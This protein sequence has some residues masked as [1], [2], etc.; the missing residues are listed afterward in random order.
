MAAEEKNKLAGC[1]VKLDPAKAGMLKDPGNNFTFSFFEG[2]TDEMKVEENTD[3]TVIERNIKVGTLR[4]FKKVGKKLK[5]VSEKFGGVP[6]P[7]RDVPLVSNGLKRPN[8]NEESEDRPLLNL[9]FSNDVNK[10]AKYIESVQDYATLQR[11]FELESQGEN[12]TSRPRPSIINLLSEKKKNVSGISMS[13]DK[14]AEEN[15]TLK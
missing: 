13:E 7:V 12:P 9:L 11:L 4:V 3:L 2:G 8:T 10:I 15:L 5:D 6:I 1:I 14:T